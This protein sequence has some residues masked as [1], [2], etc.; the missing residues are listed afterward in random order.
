[1]KTKMGRVIITFLDTG[2]GGK[3]DQAIVGSGV[4]AHERVEWKGNICVTHRRL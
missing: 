2:I 4:M 1:M 3:T